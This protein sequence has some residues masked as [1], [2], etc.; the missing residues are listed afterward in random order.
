[1]YKNIFE[2][3]Q[4]RKIGKYNYGIDDHQHP[5]VCGTIFNAP[6]RMLPKG[7]TKEPNE[8]HPDRFKILE[9][10]PMIPYRWIQKGRY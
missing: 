10:S 9:G 7:R 1:M 5:E 2:K 3:Y 4:L 6:R 8:W